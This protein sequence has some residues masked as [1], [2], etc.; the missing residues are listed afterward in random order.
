MA[1]LKAKCAIS[2]YILFTM[3]AASSRKHNVMVR[4]LSACLSQQ[5][6]PHDSPGGSM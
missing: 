2:G 3:L 5:H 4:H 1:V 6:T